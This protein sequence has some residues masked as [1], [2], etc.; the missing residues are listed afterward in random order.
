[1][2]PWEI[3]VVSI[4]KGPEEIDA[5]IRE[6]ASPEKALSLLDNIPISWIILLRVYDHLDISHSSC[7]SGY[8]ESISREKEGGA[9][10]KYSLRRIV[11]R[12]PALGDCHR[13]FL[14]GNL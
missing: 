3:P 8:I 2:Q 4:Q 12:M 14:R 6:N 9:K 5:S 1:M 13:D 10:Q 11:W 7:L